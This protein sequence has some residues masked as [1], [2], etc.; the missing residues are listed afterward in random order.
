MSGEYSIQLREGAETC[1][2]KGENISPS[3]C[4]RNNA[5]VEIEQVP[6]SHKRE[7]S[8]YLWG[9]RRDTMLLFDLAP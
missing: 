4:I 2:R 5:V 1:G 6:R 7:Q 8:T 9:L 3:A